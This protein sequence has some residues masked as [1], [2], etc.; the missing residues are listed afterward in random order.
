M[1]YLGEENHEKSS[2]LSSFPENYRTKGLSM[3]SCWS[4]ILIAVDAQGGHF[5]KRRSSGSPSSYGIAPRGYEV[6]SAW[7]HL[8]R[9]RQSLLLRWRPGRVPRVD[10]DCFTV[11]PHGI[12]GHSS[13][14]WELSRHSQPMELWKY[15]AASKAHCLLV[16]SAWLLKKDL[17]TVLEVLCELL[18]LPFISGALCSWPSWLIYWP[19]VVHWCRQLL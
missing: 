2:V 8:W 15:V 13:Q 1:L 10:F 5:F 3:G 16:D 17:V 4:F 14:L 12:T 11:D 9:I 18:Q 7:R 6:G 19:Q